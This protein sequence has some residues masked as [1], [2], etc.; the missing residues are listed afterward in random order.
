MLIKIIKLDEISYEQDFKFLKNYYA[1]K[2]IF[3]TISKFSFLGGYPT[4]VRGIKKWTLV[5]IDY[6]FSQMRN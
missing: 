1:F 5:N 4:L 2:I 6:N 3:N